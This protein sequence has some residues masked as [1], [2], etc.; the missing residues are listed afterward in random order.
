MQPPLACLGA[1]SRHSLKP[2]HLPPAATAAVPE[3]KQQ[4]YSN[5]QEGDEEE[6][7]ELR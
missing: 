1:H 7:Q 6:L 2:A 5:E 3:S 4:S